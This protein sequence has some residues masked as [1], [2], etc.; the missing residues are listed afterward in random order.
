MRTGYSHEKLT[1]LA[2]N[3]SFLV[4]ALALSY[5]DWPIWRCCWRF[6]ATVFSP[7]RPFRLPG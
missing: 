3:A 7:V 1:A 4:L 2:E 5:V 6:T